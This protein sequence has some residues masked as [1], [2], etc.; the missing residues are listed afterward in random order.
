MLLDNFTLVER[1]PVL[2]TKL[3]KV[4]RITHNISLRSVFSPGILRKYQHLLTEITA[5]S[6]RHNR[7]SWSTL[8]AL[9]LYLCFRTAH[10]LFANCRIFFEAN[11]LDM[12]TRKSWHPLFTKRTC[13]RQVDTGRTTWKTCLWCKAGDSSNLPRKKELTAWNQWIVLGIVWFLTAR[14]SLIG[15]FPCV[16]PIS[17]LCIGRSQLKTHEAGQMPTLYRC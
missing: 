2:H 8:A 4:E 5:R 14:Q 15:I 16:S 1:W 3:W 9:A 6:A 17:V 12:D 7:S 10:A 13:G 11:T